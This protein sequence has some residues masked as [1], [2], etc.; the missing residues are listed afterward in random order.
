MVTGLV[1]DE[2]VKAK[3]HTWIQEQPKTCSFNGIRKL[4][5]QYKQHVELQGDYVEKQYSCYVHV[6]YFVVSKRIFPLLFYL[7][8]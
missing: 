8:M 3:V 7:P 4:V 5:A 6:T 1:G 2:E